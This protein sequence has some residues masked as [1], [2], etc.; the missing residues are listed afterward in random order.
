M[1]TLIFYITIFLFLLTTLQA[2]NNLDKFHIFTV[3]THSNSNLEKLKQSCKQNDID[4]DV[5]GLGLPWHGN[6][7]K[8]IFALNYLK[9]F[10]DDEI[11]MFVD[12]FDVLILDNKK[13]ILDKFLKMET[14]LLIA[15]ELNCYPTDKWLINNYP[16]APTRFKYIN[17][18]T[19]IGYVK[20]IKNWLAKLQPIDA[21]MCDQAMTSYYYVK[22]KKDRNLFE[23]D[24]YCN[25]F[26]PLFNIKED[27][28]EIDAINRQV[29]CL[30]TQSSPSVVHANGFSF[31]IWDKVY[32]ALIAP[33]KPE[34]DR[35]DR[36][37]KPFCILQNNLLK[38][39]K[40]SS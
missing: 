15:A 10:G 1:R 32:E 17:T 8:L 37:Q 4:L 26:L 35:K 6:G 29:Y 12:A 14:P 25:L 18:G 3:S 20:N 2:D 16:P 39:I 19:Y 27:E 5:V 9:D 23:L 11:V 38:R 40:R 36:R 34:N 22:N 21:K 30:I 33:Y 28:V 13:T 31:L 24:Y 7:T